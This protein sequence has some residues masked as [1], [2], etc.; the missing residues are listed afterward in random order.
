MKNSF[1]MI[2][3]ATIIEIKDSLAEIKASIQVKPENDYITEKQA[4]EIFQR[5]STWFWQ[6]RKEGKLPFSKIGKTIYYSKTDIKKLF[7]Q[8]KTN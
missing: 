7:L 1:V 3:E 8:A 6:M 4:R 2:D 5:Q